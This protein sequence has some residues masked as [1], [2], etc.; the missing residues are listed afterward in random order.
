MHFA[1]EGDCEAG[2][3]AVRAAAGLRFG[4]RLLNNCVQQLSTS[5]QPS[6]A[7]HSWHKNLPT[8]HERGRCTPRPR[9]SITGYCPPPYCYTCRLIRGIRLPLGFR[10]SSKPR[11]RR[12]P[13]EF[14]TDTSRMDPLN[15]QDDE[16][17]LR[18]LGYKQVRRA[19]ALCH[20]LGARH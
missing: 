9:S 10:T 13:R 8:Q 19:T 2:M 15:A 4:L 6:K 16:G 14:D 18:A 7:M 11:G 20:P 12:S 3:L 17:V 5:E 1:L